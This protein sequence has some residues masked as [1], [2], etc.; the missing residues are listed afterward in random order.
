MKSEGYWIPSS[1]KE[2]WSSWLV[3]LKYGE[4]SLI[5]TYPGSDVG[6]RMTQLVD[7]PVYIKNELGIEKISWHL[8]DYRIE[9][10]ESVTEIYDHCKKSDETVNIFAIFGFEEMLR[11][12][13]GDLILGMQ[14]L[15][16]Q[17]DNRLIL[18]C[19]GN[20]YDPSLQQFILSLPSFEPRMTFLP[21][22]DT[23]HCHEFFGYLE[24][25]WKMELDLNLINQILLSVG[26]NL[27]FVKSIVWHLRDKGIDTFTQAIS[28][29]Q[30]LW[31][32]KCF[33]EKLSESEKKV[34]LA[35]TYGSEVNSELVMSLD[36]LKKV[37]LINDHGI[38]I[39]ILADYIHVYISDPNKLT[40]IGG[41]LIIN[42]QKVGHLFTQK[43]KNIL[44]AVLQ[45]IGQ[46]VSRE[47][48][49]SLVWDD[50]CGSDWALDSQIKR[51][52]L[53]LKE[54]GI[55]EKHLLTRRNRGLQ[56]KT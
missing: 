18:I 47:D 19:E 50:E 23:K 34:L 55:G 28:S 3:P 15:Y 42:D 56:W 38:T 26:P 52:R 16:R 20:Y 51:L 1:L 33:W 5:V 31:Q 9:K 35:T 12:K 4:P 25:K 7:D 48:V 45:N 49:I 39:P 40:T 21:F 37:G 53:R 44:K 2:M 22:Y 11:D 36:Y 30:L 24:Q 46:W 8:L 10:W 32:V 43:Q 17:K 54:T 13:R 29:Q 14:D 41:D 6:R 27:R